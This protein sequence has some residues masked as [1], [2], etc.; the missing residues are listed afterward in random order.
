MSRDNWVVGGLLW[1]EW[2]LFSSTDTGI[3]GE[4]TWVWD[5]GSGQK[6]ESN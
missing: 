2:G 6:I 3:S 1:A 5:C 4:E